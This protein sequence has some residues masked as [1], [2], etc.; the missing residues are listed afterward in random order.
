MF[1]NFTNWI[2]CKKSQLK[3]RINRSNRLAEI[4]RHWDM[5]FPTY[6]NPEGNK[7]FKKYLRLVPIGAAVLVILFLTIPSFSSVNPIIGVM[8][9]IGI[10]L[11]LMAEFLLFRPKVFDI[12][13]AKNV[14][15]ILAHKYPTE[16]MSLSDATPIDKWNTFYEAKKDAITDLENGLITRDAL[17]LHCF[18]R[19][20]LR[21]LVLLACYSI[22]IMCADKISGG[23]I[24]CSSSECIMHSS[25]CADHVF[26]DYLY[27]SFSLFLSVSSV[28]IL[29]STPGGI[30]LLFGQ[31]VIYFA[32]LIVVIGRISDYVSMYANQIEGVAHNALVK[33]LTI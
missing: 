25:V 21:T 7:G 14:H 32:V 10:F 17:R 9:G 27:K 23:G 15:N 31:I 4:A 26:A 16:V 13:S 5:T 29:T 24:L 20:L 12:L 19:I 22:I 30:L 2:Q 28:S 18:V 1:R 6:G 11:M 8:L 33:R 3:V